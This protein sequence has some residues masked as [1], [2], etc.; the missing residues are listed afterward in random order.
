MK[1]WREK[2]DSDF[3]NLEEHHELVVAER[4]SKEKRLEEQKRQYINK[5]TCLSIVYAITPFLDRAVN[6]VRK[7]SEEIIILKKNLNIVK[8]KKQ[9]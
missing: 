7:V 6:E 9:D 4:I 1:K 8:K 5:A 2:P 3:S